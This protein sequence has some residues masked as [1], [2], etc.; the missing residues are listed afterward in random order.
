MKSKNKLYPYQR[1]QPATTNYD[2]LDAIKPLLRKT[3]PYAV[4]AT[5]KSTRKS[6]KSITHEAMH[7]S[8]E[9]KDDYSAIYQ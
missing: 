4:K 6:P 9:G 5:I 2:P 1:R 8:L 3:S 7:N